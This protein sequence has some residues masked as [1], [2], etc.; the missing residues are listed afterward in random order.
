MYSIRTNI[1]SF[2]SRLDPHSRARVNLTMKLRNVKTRWLFR[3]EARRY[4]F[5]VKRQIK[6]VVCRDH[7]DILS[8]NVIKSIRNFQWIW[9]YLGKVFKF[10]KLVN[11]YSQG[12]TTLKNS[13]L[14]MLKNF[15]KVMGKHR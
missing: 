15:S 2:G 5:Y 11:I 1:S 12:W 8:T 10:M 3:F 4:W 13:K 6:L 14:T 7:R 9:K